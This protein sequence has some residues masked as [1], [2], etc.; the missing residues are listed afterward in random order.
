[1][2]T[3]RW[4]YADAKKSSRLLATREILSRHSWKTTLEIQRYTG[5][6]RPSSDISELRAN[7]ADIVCR[8]DHYNPQ[9]GNK[10]Y[11]YRMI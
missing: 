4:H 7:G 10:I 2:K 5:S 11:R 9:T 3:K 8:F 6:T 1:M